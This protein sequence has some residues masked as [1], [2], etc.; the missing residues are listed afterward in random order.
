LAFNETLHRRNKLLVYVIW[1]ML[2]LGIVVDFLTA[3]PT[4]SII[5]LAIVG[6]AACGIASVLTYKRWLSGYIKYLI[7]AIITVLTVLLIYTGPVITTYSLVYVNLAILTLYSNSRA[8]LFSGLS[9]AAVTVYLF[10]TPMKD[11]LFG[12]NDPFTMLMYLVLIAAPLYASSRF[13]ER[14]QA[15]A[16]EGREQ[17][18][19]ERNRAQVLVGDVSSSLAALNAFSSN[20]KANVTAT[21]AISKEVTASFGEVASS[22]ETQTTGI[23]D[24]SDS[25]A[26]IGREVGSLAVRSGEMKELAESSAALTASGT[27][28]AEAL[29]RRMDRVRDTIDSSAELMSGLKEQSRLIG[30]IVAAIKGISEQTNLLALNAAIEAA[31]AGEHGQGFAVVS[32]EI[33]KLAESSKQSTEQIEDILGTLGMQASQAAEQVL[34]GQAAVVE[35]G[36]AVRHVA[37]AM[38]ALKEDSD[39][40]EQQ[41]ADLSRSAGDLNVQYDRITEQVV[42]VAAATEQNMAAVQEMSA[43]MT[44]QDRRI[45]DVTESFLQLDQ[46][47]SDLSKMTN[48]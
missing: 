35:G 15:E 33:R 29:E 5:V 27:Q 34:A 1:G 4:S 45:G 24:I 7:S 3:A 43:S 13:S 17:A 26:F 9:G 28:E 44:T 47:T 36:A 48:R 38:R 41:S 2:V 39:R 12:D 19:A 32:H 18:V 14:L 6:T 42:A 46:L 23:S 22:M 20:L 37:E 11:D 8:I 10:L 31:R 21:G 40:V 25:I 30:D 16:N